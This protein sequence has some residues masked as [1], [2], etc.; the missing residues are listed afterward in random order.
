MEEKFDFSQADPLFVEAARFVVENNRMA[1]GALWS[2]NLRLVS[3]V[4]DASSSSWRQP[5]LLVR[6]CAVNLAPYSAPL[7]SWNKNSPSGRNS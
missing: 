5:V 3:F 6:L 7:R 2:V 1:W 4:P